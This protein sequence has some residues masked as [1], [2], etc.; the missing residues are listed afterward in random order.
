MEKLPNITRKE[1]YE[2]TTNELYAI[3]GKL[4]QLQEKIKSELICRGDY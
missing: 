1:L 4:S 2:M 3:N